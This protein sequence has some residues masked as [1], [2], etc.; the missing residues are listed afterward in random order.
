LASTGSNHGVG[1]KNRNASKGGGGKNRHTQNDNQSGLRPVKLIIKSVADLNST[2]IK[3]VRTGAFCRQDFSTYFIRQKGDMGASTAYKEDFFLDPSQGV[4]LCVLKENQT[5][6]GGEGSEKGNDIKNRG[7]KF[8]KGG[9]K[10]QWLNRLL[11]NRFANQS[12][13]ERQRKRL[14]DTIKVINRSSP[15]NKKRI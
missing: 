5:N 8:Q 13:Y 3:S 2:V 15:L 14:E 11:A 1:F 10:H 4:S 7:S 9:K 12:G 6:A